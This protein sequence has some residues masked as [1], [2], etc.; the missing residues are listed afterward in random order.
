MQCVGRMHSKR[1]TERGRKR[2]GII[3]HERTLETQ[4]MCVKRKESVQMKSIWN[5]QYGARYS[6][7]KSERYTRT[8]INTHAD[9]HTFEDRCEHVNVWINANGDDDDVHFSFFS[10]FLS[11]WRWCVV[12]LSAHTQS[13]SHQR[14][15]VYNTLTLWLWVVL[16]T[17]DKNN[18]HTYTTHMYAYIHSQIG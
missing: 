1:W 13:H 15:A 9:R 18:K 3:Y 5:G 6:R 11:F 8:Y 4:I 14:I 12:C 7:S 10:A 16:L 17:R 2:D